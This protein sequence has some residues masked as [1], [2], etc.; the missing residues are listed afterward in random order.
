MIRDPTIEF[1]DWYHLH[2]TDDI[3]LADRADSD[4]KSSMY[5]IAIEQFGSPAVE[6]AARLEFELE[7]PACLTVR[8]LIQQAVAKEIELR[9]LKVSAE[10][11]ADHQR[12]ATRAFARGTFAMLLDG[13][14]MADL[15]YL[16]PAND[17]NEIVFIR[18]L[19]LVG[20]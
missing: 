17:T 1:R 19:P 20:G 8:E 9:G 14:P 15:D 2:F 4:R 5:R 13:E 11:V 18:V 10:K 16:V 3:Q 7:S 6:T 12:E